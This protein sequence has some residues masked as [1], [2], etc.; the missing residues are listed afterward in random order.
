M[1]VD[2]PPAA[3]PGRRLAVMQPYFYPYAGYFRLFAAVDEFVVYDCV[4]F[5][6]RGRVHRCEVAGPGGADEWLTLPLAH[7]PRD[8]PIRELAFA[9]GA[10]AEFDRRLAR[11]PWLQA[12]DGAAAARVRAHLHGPLDGV[13]DFLEDGLALVSGLLGL[14]RPM[15]R[16]STL[17]ID[18]ALRGQARILAIAAARGATEYV[19]PPGGRHL[20]DEAAFARAGITLRFLPDYAGAYPRLLPAL[21]SDTPAAIRADVLA[22]MP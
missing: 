6:R 21:V 13:V 19:N 9:P 4:Q 20:Y 2:T 14:R 15:V 10:R 12:G 17:G 7:G 16:S 1:S 5:P 18:P 11:L 3:L 8:M 22:S